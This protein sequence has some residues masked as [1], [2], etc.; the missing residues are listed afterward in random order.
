MPAP[1]VTREA[2]RFERYVGADRWASYW[3]QL[4]TVLA[5][6]P[7]RVLEVGIGDG[8]VGTCLKQQGISYTTVDIAEDLGPDMV[9][10]VTELPFGDDSF[11]IVC[12]FE[13]LEHMPFSESERALL[14][15]ARVSSRFVLVSV[16]HFGPSVRLELKVPFLPRFRFAV[17][18][19]FPRFHAFD[20][21]HYWELGT[22]GYPVSRLRAA[23]RESFDI[24]DEFVPFE[25][26]YHHFF[27]LE[28][29]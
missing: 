21:Q 25:N 12:A 19:P 20:G 29:K 22:R 18:V 17:K 26:Q 11:D 4:R 8:V 15:C 7:R 3:Y 27:V 23:M 1:Q 5:R 24:V 10:S 28:K 14:E 13:V 6:A 2:Y 16:P 9:A